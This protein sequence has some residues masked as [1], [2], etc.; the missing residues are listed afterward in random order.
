M[1]TLPTI[2]FALAPLVWLVLWPVV[3]TLPPVLYIAGWI[4]NIFGLPCLYIV[5]WAGILIFP[6]VFVAFGSLT[7]PLLAIRIPISIVS[8]FFYNPLDIWSNIKKA[9]SEIPKILKSVDRFTSKFSL[10][11]FFIVQPTD[12]QVQPTERKVIKYWDLFIVR[13]INESKNIQN[14]YR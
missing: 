3:F 10:V 5:V 8:S 7:G 13:C 1:L 6:W 2:A 11:K 12:D 4:F 14:Y 9:L